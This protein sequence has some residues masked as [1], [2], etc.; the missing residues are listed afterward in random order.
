MRYPHD[1]LVDVRL[2]GSVDSL[3]DC[4][5]IT[6]TDMPAFV[7]LSARPRLP[8]ALNQRKALKPQTRL[9]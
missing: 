3:C 7:R 8:E 1:H 6:F 5:P 9:N 4:Q 2:C